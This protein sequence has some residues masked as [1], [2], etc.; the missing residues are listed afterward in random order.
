MN[1]IEIEEFRSSSQSRAEE[2]NSNQRHV[3]SFHLFTRL[4]NFR[5]SANEMPNVTPRDRIYEHNQIFTVERRAKGVESDLPLMKL[6]G[7]LH[8]TTLLVSDA[9]HKHHRRVRESKS[10]GKTIRRLLSRAIVDCEI[11]SLS[12]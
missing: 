4:R 5:V 3:I 1:F 6:E 10:A 9:R 7:C 2:I 11:E 8:L 12:D